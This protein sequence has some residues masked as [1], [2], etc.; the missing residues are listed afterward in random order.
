MRNVEPFVSSD[1]LHAMASL[2]P[3]AWWPAVAQSL[4]QHNGEILTWGSAKLLV[5]YQN[6]A[7]VIHWLSKRSAISGALLT[8]LA[9][10]AREHNC[11]YMYWRSVIGDADLAKRYAAIGAALIGH[12]KDHIYWRVYV[13]SV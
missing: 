11:N 12:D 3:A 4:S 13:G 6:R 2:D 8:D 5:D 7:M 10:H 9:G 1:Q